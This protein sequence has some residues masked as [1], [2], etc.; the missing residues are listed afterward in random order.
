MSGKVI[1][2]D[3]ATHSGCDID[4]LSYLP[5]LLKLALTVGDDAVTE[6]SHFFT[7]MLK[8]ISRSL[9]KKKVLVSLNSVK[10]RLVY[11]LDDS[12]IGNFIHT[13]KSIEVFSQQGFYFR[14]VADNMLEIV[15]FE[16]HQLP[17]FVHLWAVNV[18]SCYDPD[19]PLG[20]YEELFQ[21]V[22][23]VIFEYLGP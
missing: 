6:I 23:C 1:S 12:S 19:C 16:D 13:L 15:G 2:D 4:V 20:A 14:N 11:I 8:V 21:V 17:L 18:Q 9:N 10:D 5:H 3:L 22:A 7:K